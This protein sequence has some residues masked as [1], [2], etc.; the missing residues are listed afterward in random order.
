MTFVTVCVYSGSGYR[1]EA[2]QVAEDRYQRWYRENRE[3][4]SARRKVRYRS[5]PDFR[6]RAIAQSQEYRRAHPKGAR[7]LR[8]RVMKD[9]T[10]RRL[11]PRLVLVSGKRLVCFSSRD[12]AEKVGVNFTTFVGW[13]RRGTIPLPTL[14]DECGHRWYSREYVESLC[15]VANKARKGAWR[16]EAFKVAAWREVVGAGTG[17]DGTGCGVAETG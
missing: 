3:A 12:V 1:E 11:R 10:E 13:E 9:K 17:G 16:A 15:A 6:A 7:W 14:R 2:V 8:V 5:N 4:I